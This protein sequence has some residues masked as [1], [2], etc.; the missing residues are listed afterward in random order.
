MQKYVDFLWNQRTWAHFFLHFEM[1]LLPCHRQKGKPRGLFCAELLHGIAFK[2]WECIKLILPPLD[3]LWATS[4][5]SLS[6]FNFC[7]FRLAF[8]SFLFLFWAVKISPNTVFS[9]AVIHD[10]NT[11]KSHL[12]QVQERALCLC[13]SVLLIS[14][15]GFFSFK[16]VFKKT[17]NSS[18]VQE[19]SWID[20]CDFR[21]DTKTSIFWAH[22]F[23]I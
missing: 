11:D 5:F 20:C 18:Q 23:I 3:V 2:R 4:R 1:W 22:I 19:H 13:L 9:D 8:K 7:K 16:T 14:F 21:P 12:V 17:P 15:P 6:F 10:Y